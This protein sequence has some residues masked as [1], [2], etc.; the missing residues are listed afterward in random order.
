MLFD[1]RLRTQ[2]GYYLYSSVL[3]PTSYPLRQCCKMRP[4]PNVPCPLNPERTLPKLASCPSAQYSGKGSGRCL[5]QFFHFAYLEFHYFPYPSTRPQATLSQNG[6][7][8]S[9]S[10]P[11]QYNFHHIESTVYSTKFNMWLQVT[12]YKINSDHQTFVDVSQLRALHIFYTTDNFDSLILHSTT[13][14]QEVGGVQVFF[15]LAV[16]TKEAHTP[17][18]TARGG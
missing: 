2:I 7:Q 14:V 13:Q 6:G 9:L 1:L 12:H 10:R 5:I 18:N 16:S 3:G 4:P 8:T 11:M 15:Y 17:C